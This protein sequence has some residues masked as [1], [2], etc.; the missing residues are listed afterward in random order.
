MPDTSFVT[1]LL[2][3]FTPVPKA[4]EI[5]GD[6]AEERQRHGLAWYCLQVPLT[7]ALLALEALRR[8]PALLLMAYA[9]YELALKLNWWGLRPLRNAIHGRDSLAEWQQMLLNELLTSS[10]AFLFAA[11]ST[12]LACDRA[13]VVLLAATGLFLTRSAL[14]YGPGQALQLMPAVLMVMIAMLLV[15]WLQLRSP[16]SPNTT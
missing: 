6:L 14:L 9:L 13:G 7:C 15:R 16:A 8:Q 4:G 5:H 3:L 11:A 10:I 12:W 2:A 1:T